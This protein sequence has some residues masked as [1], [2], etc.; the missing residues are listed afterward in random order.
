MFSK[1][2][3]QGGPLSP[4]IFFLCME[5]LVHL[6]AVEVQNVGWK[7]LTVAKKAPKLSHMFFVDDLVLFAK[8]SLDQVTIIFKVLYKFC[9][10]SRHRI[11]KE[12]TIVF[13][14]RNIDRHVARQIGDEI[15]FKT[16]TDLRKYLG[17]PIIHGRTTRG[18]YSYRVD[19]LQKCNTSYH[20][21][22]L[23]LAGR[24]TLVKSIL[25]A[26][27]VYTMQTTILP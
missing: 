17:L 18:T 1:G 7:P 11:S 9:L 15:G 16:T 26:L 3:R 19:K 22:R 24:K 21:T 5:R 10:A 13:F 23:S 6:I 2:I 27:P 4:Y 14:S 12:K 25:S 8:A 20:T